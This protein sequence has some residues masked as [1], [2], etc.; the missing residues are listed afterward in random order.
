M[1]T[2]AESGAIAFVRD[3]VPLD[4]NDHKFSLHLQRTVVSHRDLDLLAHF[5]PL[6]CPGDAWRLHDPSGNL[7]TS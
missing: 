6:L 3:L 2:A 4:V 7:E 5:N 1:A